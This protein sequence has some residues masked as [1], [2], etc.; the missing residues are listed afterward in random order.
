MPLC[1]RR[2]GCA[3]TA[4]L[5]TLVLVAPAAAAPTATVTVSKGDNGAKRM[6][7]RIGPFDI[8]PG[9]NEINNRIIREKPAVDGWITRIR[10]DLVYTS[11]KVPGV[12][13]IHLHHGVWAN[14]SRQ[15]SSSPFAE[16]FFA[17]GEEK[18]V[19]RIPEGYG[20]EYTASDTWVL[21]HMI[22]NLTPVPTQ[23]YMVYEIDFIPKTS[24]HAAGITPVH[25]VWMDVERGS[26]YPVFDVEKGAG[27]RGAT[28]TPTTT[29]RPTAVGPPRTSG[30][31]TAAECWWPPPVTCI[32]EGFTTISGCGARARA[33]TRA[34]ARAR[35]RREPA[36][37]AAPTRPGAAGPTPISSAPRPSTSS[38]RAP[39]RGTSP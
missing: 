3:L 12:D 17:A 11:G 16:L 6:T 25:P 28:P 30:R 39:C 15:S 26:G 24:P 33:S 21:N 37:A 10:P 4:V 19:M 22:H 9:Q 5:T 18:T 2:A 34:A 36:S 14:I 1:L 27:R 38:P 8:I 23:V 20:Y 35:P 32:P 13:V 31:P 7:Y 29:R